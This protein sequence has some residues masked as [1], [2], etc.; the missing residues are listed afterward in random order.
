MVGSAVPR[1]LNTTSS[2]ILGSIFKGGDILASSCDSLR[3]PRDRLMA[4]SGR[5]DVEAVRLR[6]SL[7]PSLEKCHVD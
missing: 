3:L 7:A 6:V 1:P 4:R 2:P 5:C